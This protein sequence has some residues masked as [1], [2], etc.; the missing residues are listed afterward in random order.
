P[1]YGGRDEQE[2]SY[3]RGYEQPRRFGEAG[4][5]GDEGGYAPAEE[6]QMPGAFGEEDEFLEAA[7]R[8]QRGGYGGGGGW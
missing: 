2:P 1:G 6:G 3:G 7:S 8:R 4:Y 5:G